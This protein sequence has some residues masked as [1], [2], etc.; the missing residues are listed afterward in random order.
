MCKENDIKF[1]RIHAEPHPEYYLDAADEMG[2]M[3][4][5]ETAIYGSAKSMA[6]D[7]PLYI[8]RCKKHIQRLVKRDRNHPSVVV[9]SLMNEMRWVDG[10][11]VFKQKV[12]ELMEEFR[13]LDMTRNIILDGDNRLIDKERIEID[14]MHYDVDGTIDQWERKHPLF[15]GEHGGWWYICPQN[16]SVYNGLNAYMGFDECVE[17]TALKEKL[18]MEYA[19]R[20]GVTSVTPFNMAHYMARSM[21]NED[22][23]MEYDR[24]D[25]PGPKPKVLRRYSYTIND[26]RLEGYPL[27]IPNRSYE[28]L[29][30]AYKAVTIIPTEY[31]TYFYDD[32]P[33]T[34][35]YDVYNDT[36]KPKNCKIEFLLKD[37]NNL[38]LFEKLEEF[39]QLPADDKNISIT[40]TPPVVNES[41][42]LMLEAVLYHDNTEIYRLNKV[43]KIYPSALRE[44]QIQI[45]GLKIAY[46]GSGESCNIIKALIP[47]CAQVS[48]IQGICKDEYDVLIIGSYIN[49]RAD[50]FNE[51]LNSYVKGGGVVVQLEQYKF[52]P[53]DLTLSRQTFFSAHINNASHQLVKGLKDEDLI[54]WKPKVWEIFPDPII[55]QCFE[56]P[57]KGDFDMVLECSAGDHSDGGTL[58]TP[59]FEYKHEKG[60]MIFNQFDLISN[61]NDIPQACILLR[62]I[63]EYAVS[64]KP[65]CKSATGLLASCQSQSYEFMQ[66]LGL[67]F[68]IIDDISSLSSFKTI[69]VDMNCVTEAVAANLSDFAKKGGQV[70]VLPLGKDKEKLLSSILG[71]S[72]RINGV[73][74][75]QLR[76]VSEDAAINGVSIYDLFRFEKVNF[77]PRLVE[78]VVICHNSIEIDAAE[79]LLTSVTGTPW[80]DYY[81]RE[82]PDEYCRIAIVSI[83]RDKKS[84][85][86]P[87]MAKKKV[88]N[89][90]VI[91]MQLS[92]DLENE[93]DIR[94][95]SKV[96]SN[97]GAQIDT[98]MFS[99]IKGDRDYSVNF[100]MTL[101]HEEYKDYQKAEE[102]YSDKEYSLN[103]LGEGL[104]GWMKKIEKDTAEGFINIKGS[105]G[106]TY[107]LSCFVDNLIDKYSGEAQIDSSGYRLDFDT[108]CSFK[109]WING[110]LV[111]ENLKTSTD[112]ERVIVKNITLSKGLNRFIIVAKANSEDIRFRPVF[113]TA[114]G[115][116]IDYIKYQLTIDEVDPK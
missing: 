8:E 46:W 85:E 87:Y 62:N 32:K 104:Y 66:K 33:I 81:V 70:L 31:N 82:V 43:Y 29:K 5:D 113:K 84:P 75:Y 49:V 60:T 99:Y 22:I 21:P 72:V 10:R 100:F 42:E 103:N 35:S 115:E 20:N 108:N 88:G 90:N 36:M 114:D 97:L 93:K 111:K 106:H 52:A 38:I 91:V 59:L 23:R 28:V 63:L 41:T 18:F 3:L 86:L 30:D 73:E 68:E 56:K 78:N 110:E 102:Y 39:M 26:G 116:Y 13:K 47:S 101:P 89:G 74:T 2:I 53:G 92:T 24:L 109:T 4:I 54:F 17:G 27:Y 107:F 40:F 80:Y 1:V 25:T 112:I 9:W 34:R 15:F 58:W 67:S 37:K 16:S 98:G 71:C 76:S 19:R 6:A 105:A 44:K 94:I 95:Y 61:F 69:V 79:N 55:E 83:N 11:E 96:L 14:S 57:V 51:T 48:D 7:H 77:T 12:P 65:K 45:N 50:D 64:V